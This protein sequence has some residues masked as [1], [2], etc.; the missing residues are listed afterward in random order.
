MIIFYNE[1][2]LYNIICYY[3]KDHIYLYTIIH[4]PILISDIIYTYKTIFLLNYMQLYIKYNE[5]NGPAS[6]TIIYDFLPFHI[7]IYDYNIIIL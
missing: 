2:L 6:Y 1:I 3:Y 5:F 7:I 4:N